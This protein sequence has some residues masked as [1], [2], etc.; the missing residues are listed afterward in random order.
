MVKYYKLIRD[1]GKHFGMQ[2]DEEGLYIDPNHCAVENE[3]SGIHFASVTHILAMLDYGDNVWEVKVNPD[4]DIYQVEEGVFKSQEIYISNKRP[5]NIQTVMDLVDE[6][7][8]VTCFNN[9]PII[10]ASLY[11]WYD[12]F[13]FMHD[14]GAD[15]FARNGEPLKCAMLNGSRTIRIAE[16][17]INH[18]HDKNTKNK[19]SQ[20][21]RSRDLSKSILDKPLDKPMNKP[22]DKPMNK[23][24]IKIS[25]K[26]LN[27]SPVE[28]YEENEYII[29]NDDIDNIN[30]PVNTINIINNTKYGIQNWVKFDIDN[31]P[32]QS[33]IR[34][35]DEQYQ[36]D[37]IYDQ[38]GTG[39]TN[40]IYFETESTD[41]EYDCCSEPESHT[42]SYK[43]SV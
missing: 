1:D 13:M 25:V 16:Y 36:P 7:A 3:K 38:T 30:Q 41:S 8:D 29:S 43:Q 24:P 6:G 12:L 20:Y 9:T 23:P 17:I 10:L 32:S 31:E 18:M 34:F 21:L 11:G 28:L 33:Y 35:P 27:Q 22:L 15:I 42:D 2:Y 14:L 40:Q 19:Y 5:I 37:F 4:I 26:P 39:F